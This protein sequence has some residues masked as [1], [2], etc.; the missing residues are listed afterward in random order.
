MYINP[1]MAE[2]V[3]FFFSTDKAV[4]KLLSVL[5][6]WRSTPMSISPMHESAPPARIELQRSFSI[7]KPRVGT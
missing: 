6:T 7:I 3:E 1:D 4:P 5:N 2:L